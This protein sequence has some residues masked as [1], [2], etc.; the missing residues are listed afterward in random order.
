MRLQRLLGVSV[1]AAALL[2]SINCI[3]QHRQKNARISSERPCVEGEVG[4]MSDEES[5]EQEA[6][7][8]EDGEKAAAEDGEFIEAYTDKKSYAPGDT[9]VFHVSTN[10]PTYNIK[11]LRDGWS[12][13]TIT[14]VAGLPGA[15][16]PPPP[17]EEEPWR[18]GAG[19]P[20]GHTMV[21]PDSWVTGSYVAQFRTEDAT[22][23]YHPFCIRPVV[24]G[25]RSNLAYVLNFNTRNAY[26]CWGGK[27]LYATLVPG[28]DHKA[29]RVSFQR[30]FASEYGRGNGYKPQWKIQSQ[31]VVEGFAPEYLTEWD[32]HSNPGLLRAYDV[33]VLSRAH[34][35]VTAEI[36]DALE[37]HH[38]RG[39]HLAFFSACDIFWQVRYEDDGHTMLGY[40]KYAPNEDPLYG[41]DDDLVTHYWDG[42]IVNRPPDPLKGTRY[43]RESYKF[44]NEDYV[45]QMSSHWIFAGTGLQDGEP[46]GE[47]MA[48]GETDYMGAESPAELDVVLAAVRDTVRPG[49]SASYDQVHAAA[50]YFADSP[51]YGFPDGRGG[52]VFSAGTTIGWA[53]GIS[54]VSQD[55]QIVRLVTRNIIQHMLDSPPPLFGDDDLDDH[56]DL[57]DFTTLADCLAGPDE[58]PEPASPII[59][60][61][62]QYAFD[63]DVD[64]DVDLVD[65]AAF[66]IGFTGLTD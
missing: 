55:Y 58:T 24:P 49:Y 1:L 2:G 51:D 52:Q 13:E 32:I 47:L 45:V 9:I 50:V 26:N 61:D 41:V 27:S 10:S 57:T 35:Y 30:P 28:D 44:M 54:T 6:N 16:Y 53:N 62:C 19:W 7:D 56:V 3:S 59:V 25:S 21:V 4:D 66:Q 42:D 63:S 40:K 15:Y 31:L 34:E 33:V 29:V 65:F 46:F 22:I 39:G 18:T 23:A 36:Y 11:I 14:A 12:R 8:L 48:A 37:F 38:L 43:Q 64:L 17:P 20:A 5:L 60:E